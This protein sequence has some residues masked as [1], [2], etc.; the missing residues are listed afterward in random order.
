MFSSSLSTS[1]SHALVRYYRVPPSSRSYQHIECSKG[2]D[3]LSFVSWFVRI[4]GEED[5]TLTFRFRV[6]SEPHRF[7]LADMMTWQGLSGIINS[8]RKK[9]LGLEPL[10]ALSGPSVV[11]RLKVRRLVSFLAKVRFTSDLS[12]PRYRSLGRTAGLKA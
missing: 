11:D 5:E 3:E 12:L 9:V 6:T 4:R 2:L 1:L 8:F 7:S 10:S